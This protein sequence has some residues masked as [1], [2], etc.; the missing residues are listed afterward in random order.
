LRKIGKYEDD[1]MHINIIKI[2]FQPPVVNN[3]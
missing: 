1:K 2:N 3:R